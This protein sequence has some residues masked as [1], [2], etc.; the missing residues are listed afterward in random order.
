MKRQVAQLL[1]KIGL[2]QPVKAVAVAI[3][4]HETKE[5]GHEFVV[6]EINRRAAKGEN[7]TGKTLIEIGTTRE[8][9]PGLGS[10]AILAKLCHRHG[11][12]MITVDMD[13]ENTEAARK[14]VLGL[15]ESFRAV[16]QKGEE[17]LQAFQSPIDFIYLDAF[18]FE[19]PNHSDKRKKKYE[20]LLGTTINNAA[21]HKMHLDCAIEIVRLAQSGTTVVFDDVWQEEGI[22]KGKGETAIPYFI[23]HGF[24]ITKMGKNSVTLI[25]A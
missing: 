4:L 1:D 24:K 20:A 17:F 10:T 14:Q 7:L 25:L 9:V 16:T 13:S 6:A 8:N 11:M 15:G 2:K 18:D 19:H 12:R 22:W 23:A 3:G 21:C 5:H